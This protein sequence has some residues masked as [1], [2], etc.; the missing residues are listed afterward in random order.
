MPAE[1]LVA[2][3]FIEDRVLKAMEEGK[4]ITF[5]V[6]ETPEEGFGVTGSLDGFKQAFEALP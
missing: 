6:F 2:E 1:R 3:V 5:V 4:K